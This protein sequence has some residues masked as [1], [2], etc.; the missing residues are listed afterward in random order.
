MTYQ[1][2]RFQKK[3]KVVVFDMDGTLIKEHCWAI[4]HK[5]FGVNWEETQK[6]IEAYA[7]GKL[8][9][10]KL[11]KKEIKLWEKNGQ[12]PHID[13]VKKALKKYTLTKNAV[14]TLAK[15]HQCGYITALVTYGLDVLAEMVASQLGI[16]HVYANTLELTPQGRLTGNQ[17]NRVELGKKDKIIRELSRKLRIPLSKFVVV[18]DTKYD[19]S[20]FKGAGLKIAFNPKHKEL[21][22]A[23]DVVIRSEDLAQI[24]RYL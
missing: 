2:L 23:A 13:E 11:V 9:F 19:L 8:S 16:T 18:G 3:F 22:R 10:E 14:K 21:I 12:L 1:N 6:N 5:H 24:L 17:Y 7:Q 4:L 15:L 20:M